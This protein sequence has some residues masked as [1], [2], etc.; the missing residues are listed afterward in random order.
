MSEI[1]EIKAQLLNGLWL[2]N[3]KKGGEIFHP[4]LRKNK[5][6]K[7]LTLTDDGNFQEVVRFEENYL[8]T[9]DRTIAWTHSHLKKLRLETELS[10][11]RVFGT[12]RYEDSISSSSFSLSGYF[13]FD[14]INLDFSCQ[15]PDLESGRVEKE[16]ESLE[17]TIK[18]QTE[19]NNMGFVLIYTT[20]LN[21]NN[22]DCTNIVT[23]S[24]AIHVP[25][26][27][28]LD[29]GGFPPSIVDH[30][31]KIRCLKS[32]ITKLCLKYSR[33]AHNDEFKTKHHCIGRTQ[34]RVCSILG[35]LGTG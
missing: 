11:A 19:H 20:L 30:M 5:K 10:P 12:T 9:R 17:R 23:T 3:V 22:L 21:S 8:I 2:P 35:L 31:E 14:I 15:N 29:L 27:S 6:M 24:N 13:P 25:Q 7:L 28:G 33:C 4:R 26:W 34:R 18:L 16:L 1:S 32:V